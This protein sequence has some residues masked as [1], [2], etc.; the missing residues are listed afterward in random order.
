MK[1]PTIT[2]INQAKTDLRHNPYKMVVALQQYVDNCCGPVWNFG[3]KMRFA[4]KAEIGEWPIYLLD[5]PDQA[6]ALGYHDL[7]QTPYAKIFVKPTIQ[8]GD[9]ICSTISHELIEM[10]ADPFIYS[11][12]QLTDKNGNPIN[13]FY[14]F[15]LAD[16]VENTQFYIDGFAMSNFITPQWYI[17]NATSGKFDYM[18]QCNKPLEILSGGYMSIYKNGQWN[19][20][21]GS[22]AAANNFKLQHHHRVE[23]RH[24]E[25]KK[26]YFRSM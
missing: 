11:T 16:A 4:D 20:V 26:L 2:L 9:D 18:G 22:R 10:L 6:N 15:E 19:Q 14:A 3:C 7:T 5:D 12:V 25:V 8:A 21:F 13:T 23:R 1:V 17:A 24:G